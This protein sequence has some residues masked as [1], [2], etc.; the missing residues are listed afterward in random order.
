MGKAKVAAVPATRTRPWLI[1]SVAAIVWGILTIVVLHLISS[2]NPVFDTLSSYAFTD[3][4]TGMLGASVLS[5]SIGSLCLLGALYAAGIQLSR[6]TVILFLAWSL[7]LA[8]AAM[9]P[10]SYVTN[11]NPVSGEIHQY[12]CLIAFL[13]MPGIGFSV[14]DKIGTSPAFAASRAMVAKLSRYSLAA[15]ALF[16]LSYLLT[17]FPDSPMLSQFSEALPVGVMQRIALAVDLALL[18]GLMVLASR[19]A[20]LK[21]F[22]GLREVAVEAGQSAGMQENDVFAHFEVASAGPVDQR[23]GSLA[24]V[25]RIEHNSFRTA[26]EPQRIP[27]QPRRHPIAGAERAVVHADVLQRRRRDP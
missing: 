5:L 20:A 7:G 11:P 10:A 14:L 2:H 19:A 22:D 27:H 4:G 8:T 21:G 3:R 23:R 1:A 26:E 17:D 13:S 15:L 25:D 18:F 9:F 12:S 16:G 24:G 6:T